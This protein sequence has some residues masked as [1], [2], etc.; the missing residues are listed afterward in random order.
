[1]RRPGVLAAMSPFSTRPRRR[2]ATPLRALGEYGVA[3][4]ILT[5]DNEVVT[6][7][8]CKRGGPRTSHDRDW[9]GKVERLDRRPTRRA[10]R[11]HHDLRQAVADA[12]SRASFARSR[13][14]ATRSAI[15]ATAS[16][17]RPRSGG[18]R[19]HLGG[20]G[21]GRRQGIRRHHPAGKEPARAGGGVIEGRRRSATSSNTSR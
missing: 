16:T 4:K 12:E 17:T 2:R 9:C 8:I 13:R 18:R 5:G 20:H 21:G 14:T 1:M 7:K 6:R 19:G 3:V 10:G 15:W 11:T